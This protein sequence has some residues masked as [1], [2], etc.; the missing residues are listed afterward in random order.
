MTDPVTASALASRA[1]RKVPEWAGKIAKAWLG[2]FWHLSALAKIVATAAEI[3]ALYLI[4]S[5][6]PLAAASRMGIV[7]VGSIG[8]CF[9]LIAGVLFGRPR[10]Q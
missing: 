1:L 10:R 7:Q 8:L 2:W 6:L 9:F 4:C 5:Q 3:V